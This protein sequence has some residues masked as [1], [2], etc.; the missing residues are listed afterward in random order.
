[1]KFEYDGA[2]ETA[3]KPVAWLY[4][5]ASSGDALRLCVATNDPDRF[6]WMYYDGYITIQSAGPF[7][8]PLKVFYEGDPITITF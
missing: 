3:R 2:V 5:I 8:E 1:M 4:R 7:G 6:I